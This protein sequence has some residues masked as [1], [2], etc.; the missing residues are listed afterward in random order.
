MFVCGQ[1]KNI[2]VALHRCLQGALHGEFKGRGWQHR[3]LWGLFDLL[4]ET[5]ARGDC[6]Q[7]L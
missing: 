6:S 3:S 5:Q 7:F 2:S 1:K 4:K